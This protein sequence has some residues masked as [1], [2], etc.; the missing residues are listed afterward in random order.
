[1]CARTRVTSLTASWTEFRSPGE[2]R[3]CSW[4]VRRREGQS[5]PPTGQ[6]WRSAW[7]SRGLGLPLPSLGGNGASAEAAPPATFASGTGNSEA[8]AS[9]WDLQSFNSNDPVEVG[10]ASSLHE[11]VVAHVTG[12]TASAYVG[13]WNHF[14]NWC[15]SLAIPRCPLPSSEITV[16][17]YL[18]YVVQ[19]SKSY[20][21]VKSH[22]AAIAFY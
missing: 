20:G 1:M 12:S 19:R 17:L 7:T 9:G 4:P 2:T 14:V 21:P 6:S 10:L 13:P 18:R 15:A 5:C 16:A 22:S 11:V 3:P 8:I